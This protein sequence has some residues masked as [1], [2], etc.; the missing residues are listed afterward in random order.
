[1]KKFLI[2]FLFPLWASSQDYV[3]IFKINYGS[4]SESTFDGSS[5]STDVKLFD[6]N[7][8]YPI[9]LNDKYTLITGAD[10]SATS[11]HLFPD[12]ELTRLYSTTLNLGLATTYSDKWSSTIV[13]LP[14]LA[15]DY[16]DISGRDFYMGGF[17]VVKL[18]KSENFKY[19]FGLY[20]SSEAFGMTVTPI[21]GCY[22]I[23]P[24]NRFEI[25]ASLPIAAD[26]NYS[27]GFATVGFDYEGLGRS[28]KLDLDAD[29]RI[30][31]EQ[32][33][34]EFSSY[35]QFAAFQNALLM[36]AKIGYTI[37]DYEVYEESDQL[38]LQLSAIEFGAEREMLNPNLTDVLFFKLEMIYRFHI[39]KDNKESD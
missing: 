11:L 14:K 24:N 17:A 29:T 36:R 8:I 35:V 7:F 20:M 27:L 21:I 25:D 13:L 10:F 22:Y 34:L 6:V 33:P 1:M 37:N 31:V 32:S 18:K 5:V 30:Y 15:S 16:K 28:Y 23:S 39:S 3:D 38:D 12:S 19:R 2:L 4:T 26:I 9:V